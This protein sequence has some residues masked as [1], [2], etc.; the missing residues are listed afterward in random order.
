[1]QEERSSHRLKQ[2]Y[3]VQRRS[4]RGLGWTLL[5]VGILKQCKVGLVGIKCLG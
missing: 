5:E 4:R 2:E 1:M 3:G